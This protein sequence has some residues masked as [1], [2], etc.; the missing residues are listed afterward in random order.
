MIAQLGDEEVGPTIELPDGE[1][2]CE[3][4]IN[5]FL[6]FGEFAQLALSDRLLSCQAGGEGSHAGIC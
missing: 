4:V 6:L 2:R 3:V 1:V 5:P